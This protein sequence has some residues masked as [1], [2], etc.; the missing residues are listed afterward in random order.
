MCH[1]TQREAVTGGVQPGPL[2]CPLL[3]RSAVTTTSWCNVLDMTAHS[4]IVKVE[5]EVEKR[6]GPV[7]I[8]RND[9][10]CW[11]YTGRFIRGQKQVACDE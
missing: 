2:S 4:T 7:V 9:L 5:T 11:A 6:Y 10:N 1:F 8:A 3:R